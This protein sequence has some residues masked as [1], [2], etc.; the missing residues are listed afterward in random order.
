MEFDATVIQVRGFIKPGS[1]PHFLHKKMHVPSENMTVVIHSFDVF[2]LLNL[3]YD[4]DLYLEVD[5]EVWLKTKL[6]GK[7]DDFSL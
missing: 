7:R 5:Y 6:Y 3:P 2:E 4:L 1:I